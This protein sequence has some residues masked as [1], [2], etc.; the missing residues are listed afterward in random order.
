MRL[1]AVGVLTG[2]C[3][4]GCTGLETVPEPEVS[5]S[6]TVAALNEHTPEPEAEPAPAPRPSTAPL[7]PLDVGHRWT[8]DITERKGAGIRI[9]G[10][11][12]EK[13]TTSTLAEWT[14]E[15]TD[16][17]G[18]RYTAKLTRSP[19]GDELPSTTEMTLWERD[20]QVWMDAGKGERLAMEAVVPPNP[21]SSER[22]RCVAHMLGGAVGS[23][24][25]VAGGPLGVEPGL[26]NGVVGGHVK[27]GADVAQFLV[28]IATVGIFIPGNKS[29]VQ[30]AWRTEFRPGEGHASRF[31]AT[32]DPLLAA[33]RPDVGTRNPGERLVRAIEKHGAHPESV[34]AALTKVNRYDVVDA[35]VEVLPVCKPEDRY[36][37]VRVAI[38]H[39]DQ[40]ALAALAKL[41]PGLDK[42]IP[43]DHA[44]A[45]LALFEEP[46]QRDTAD[47]LI[48]GSSTL[49]LTVV[50]NVEGPFDSDVL[51]PLEEALEHHPVNASDV[52]PIA[53]LCTFDDCRVKVGELMLPKLDSSEHAAVVVEVIDVLS[54]DDPKLELI[55]TH[56]ELLTALPRGDRQDLVEGISFER[57][58]ARELLGL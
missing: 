42:E 1:A 5:P 49:L 8:Y 19:T 32:N 51:E 58:E 29:T 50:G 37:V 43:S 44:A 26:D 30:T 17:Q 18:E 36:P 33:F 23:C 35:A 40:P 46:E 13:P 4:L 6:E 53:R 55:R 24:A 21:V 57:E 2:L 22:I 52:A 20:G 11:A 9:L 14:F 39:A 3:I 48:D 7:L 16:K 56:Q 54:F 25:P 28:G 47:A 34:T 12:T 41:R 31:A 15:I 10:F 27:E 45:L 38:Q